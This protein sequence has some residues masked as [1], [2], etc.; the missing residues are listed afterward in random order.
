MDKSGDWKNVNLTR[1]FL[2]C[3]TNTKSE[4]FNQFSGWKII[5]SDICQKAH[6][7]TRKL[8]NFRANY[9][10]YFIGIVGLNRNLRLLVTVC[11]VIAARSVDCVFTINRCVLDQV[12]NDYLYIGCILYPFFSV[13]QNIFWVMCTQWQF[14]FSP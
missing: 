3:E 11:A 9:R 10:I 4:F 12:L 6:T 13:F 1:K 2:R 8:L 7:L 5:Q 14:L